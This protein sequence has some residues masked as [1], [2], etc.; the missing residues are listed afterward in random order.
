MKSNYVVSNSPTKSWSICQTLTKVYD[1]Y[2]FDVES[3]LIFDF[4]PNQLRLRTIIAEYE[5]NPKIHIQT[6]NLYD[7]ILSLVEYCKFR[8]YNVDGVNENLQSLILY[9]VAKTEV[10]SNTEIYKQ[11]AKIDLTTI[12]EKEITKLIN[13]LRQDYETNNKNQSFRY[14]IYLD[15]IYQLNSN[16]DI[17]NEKTFERDENVYCFHD[18]NKEYRLAKT[19]NVYAEEKKIQI[20]W[21]TNCWFNCGEKPQIKTFDD[22][23]T[24]QDFKHWEKTVFDSHYL[25]CYDSTNKEMY[26]FLAVITNSSRTTWKFKV[27]EEERYVKINPANC[28]SFKN[29]IAW[30]FGK[31]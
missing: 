19:Q 2:N 27:K 28:I 22:C 30:H 20:I 12:T 8:M 7:E 5:F 6:N 3:N 4:I 14:D 10:N 1:G 29:H 31:K 16:D 21:K 18:T 23:H 17:K 11:E 26:Y 24:Q 9:I 25:Y 13:N 15:I